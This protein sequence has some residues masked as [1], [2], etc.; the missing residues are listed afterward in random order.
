MATATLLPNAEQQFVDENGVP[1]AGGTVEFYV[2]GTLNFKT[3]WQDPN[4]TTQNTNPVVLDAAG[5]AIIFGLGDYRQILRDQNGVMIWDQLTQGFLDASA[6][7]VILPCLG[8][9]TLQAFRDCA[10]ISAAI[11]AAIAN[12]ALL[13]G[14]QGVAGATGPI[15]P[16]G[17]AGAAGPTGPSG[18]GGGAGSDG[19]IVKSGIVN[20]DAG[21]FVTVTYN[22]PFP[23]AVVW[24]N[25]QSYPQYNQPLVVGIGITSS[26]ASG[27]TAQITD[28][29]GNV[30]ANTPIGWFSVGQ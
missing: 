27:F 19:G 23:T 15:G 4:Q 29:F 2:P 3:T 22:T 13:P 26:T 30:L 21:G 10:G 1:Y 7:G 8:A 6:I 11:A 5:R 25:L 17:P 24:V 28:Q 20:S 18:G 9:Q 14:P 16:T 12:V